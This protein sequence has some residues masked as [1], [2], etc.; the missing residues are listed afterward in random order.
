MLVYA[1][2]GDL[3]RAQAQLKKLNLFSQISVLTNNRLKLITKKPVYST[4]RK[5]IEKIQN[6]LSKISAISP[7]AFYPLTKKPVDNKKQQ[8][9]SKIN[10]DNYRRILY[11]FFDIDSTLTHEGVSTI[12]SDIKSDFEDFK[13]H[14]CKLYFCSGRSYQDINRLMK[15]YN[16]KPYGIAESG[17]IILG[18]G[19]PERGLK[20]GDRTEPDKVLAYLRHNGIKY[21]EDQNQVNRRTEVVIEKKSIKW[22]IL[23][24][25]IKHSK[26]KVDCRISKAAYHITKKGVDKGTAIEYL[27][28]E[29]LELNKKIHKTI[30]VGDSDL[31]IPMIQFCDE[32]YAVANC[33]EMVKKAIQKKNILKNKAPKAIEELYHRLFQFG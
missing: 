15:M 19:D 18:I 26:A 23:K 5:E 30:G 9:K 2:Y 20:F 32:F 14:E 12:N 16:L 29:E 7:F 33:D 4:D 22:S 17:G 13:K 25:A 21:S 24:A 27:K 6:K 31:D 10:D 1:T 28:S 8:T 3:R 11:I